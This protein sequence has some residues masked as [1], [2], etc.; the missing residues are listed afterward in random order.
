MDDRTSPDDQEIAAENSELRR[1]SDFRTAAEYV[2][3]ASPRSRK[4]KGSFYLAPLPYRWRKKYRDFVTIGKRALPSGT[5]AVT[6]TWRCGLR[7]WI[8]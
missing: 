2:A 7:G 6:W 3:R 1:Q 5:N 4:C 8:I